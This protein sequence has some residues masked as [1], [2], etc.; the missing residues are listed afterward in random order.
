[1]LNMLLSYPTCHPISKR[2][3]KKEAITERRT[4]NHVIDQ[5]HNNKCICRPKKKKNRRNKEKK[6]RETT[7]IAFAQLLSPNRPSR[8]RKLIMSS[9]SIDSL[10]Q[11][12]HQALL[13]SFGLSSL[14]R[15]RATAQ[16]ACAR[17]SSPPVSR[18]RGLARELAAG[19]EHL[20]GTDDDLL[21]VGAVVVSLL[22]D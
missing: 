20:G 19:N 13:D 6:K 22:H 12:L 7:K 1:M 18:W 9:S 2:T 10:T 16:T 17:R 21:I 5:S 11:A 15:R 8:K 14:R 3:T 4:R